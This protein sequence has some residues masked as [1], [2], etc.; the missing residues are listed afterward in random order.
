[1]TNKM[2]IILLKDVTKLGKKFDTKDVSPGYA[3][4]LLIPNGLAIPATKEAL[5]R[6]ELERARVE[7]ERKIQGE[8]LMENI[9]SLDG[10][11]LTILSKANEKG[12]LFAGI[13]REEIAKELDSQLHLSIDSTSIIL[14]HPIKEVG[15]HTIEVKVEGKSAKFKVVV[16]AT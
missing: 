6:F 1:M 5:K 14:E 9:K 12:H 2:K 3:T 4:N 11:T 8:L 16:Q 15:E 10:V 7:G 13:H